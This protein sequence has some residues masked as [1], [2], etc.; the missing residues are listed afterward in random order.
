[1]VICIA[2]YVLVA[3]SAV[4]SMPFTKFA[5]SSE[6]LAFI[7]RAL[8]SPGAAGFV[9]IVAII[10]MPTVILAFMYGQTR[11]FFVM[12]RDGLLPSRFGKLS[13]KSGAP[14]AVTMVTGF[15]CAVLAGLLPLEKVAALANAGTLLAFIATAAGLIILRFREPNLER[16]FKVPL[17]IL[18]ASLAI[19][20]CLYLFYSLPFG[21]QKG[22]FIW[23]SLGVVVYFVY[24]R[25][26][27]NLNKG[28]AA[29][30]P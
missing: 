19:L 25:N 15:I 23:M 29:L 27:S 12:A 13:E 24:S 1:M 30:R 20:G 21:T 14:V 16:P 5:S 22:F 26:V 17:G 8:G 3:L 11:V 4:G 18:V 9:A 6:P 7:L 2:I 10:A 28:N